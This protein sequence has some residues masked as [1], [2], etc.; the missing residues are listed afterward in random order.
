MEKRNIIRNKWI[1]KHTKEFYKIYWVDRGKYQEN[2]DR[3]KKLLKGSS[4][5]YSENKYINLFMAAWKVYYYIHNTYAYGREPVDNGE[6]S[7]EFEMFNNLSIEFDFKE[8][9]QSFV[10]LENFM[11]RVI[12]F[13][14]D[15]DLDCKTN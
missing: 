11:D 2:N 1:G 3:I 7:D 8:A 13:I 9:V 6:F 4:S 5:G 12:E 14:M 10:Y 15:K